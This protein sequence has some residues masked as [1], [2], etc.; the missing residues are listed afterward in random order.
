MLMFGLLRPVDPDLVPADLRDLVTD[1]PWEAFPGSIASLWGF[2]AAEVIEHVIAS[3][4]GYLIATAV[5]FIEQALA[6]IGAEHPERPTY[7]NNL[8]G[9]RHMLFQYRGERSDL[10]GALA[11]A[12]EAVALTAPEHAGRAARAALLASLYKARFDA[13]FD[14]TERREDL[15]AAVA[16]FAEAV[17]GLPDDHIDRA[18][19]LTGWGNARLTRYRLDRT[20]EDLEAAATILREAAKLNLPPISTVP[21]GLYDCASMLYQHFVAIGETADLDNAIDCFHTALALTGR[22]VTAEHLAEMALAHADAYLLTDDPWELSNFRAMAAEVARTLP[23]NDPLRMAITNCERRLAAITE[24][25]E[26]LRLRQDVLAR[27]DAFRRGD[28]TAVLSGAATVDATRLLRLSDQLSDD[29]SVDGPDLYAYAWLQWYRFFALPDTV[30]DDAFALAVDGFRLL[31]VHDVFDQPDS[32]PAVLAI[33]DDGPASGPLRQAVAL[34]FGGAPDGA[35]LD[36]AIRKLGRAIDATAPDSP[37]HAELLASLAGAYHERYLRDREPGDLDT[38]ITNWRGAVEGT[39]PTHPAY[40]AWLNALAAGHHARFRAC[41]DDADIDAAVDAARRADAATS[42]TDPDW[43]ATHAQVG[44]TSLARY[45]HRPDGDDLDEAITVLGQVVDATDDDHDHR[46]LYLSELADARWK[47]Y[48]RGRDRSDLE[49]AVEAYRAALHLAGVSVDT[50]D[51]TQ[52]LRRALVALSRLGDGQALRSAVH[53]AREALTVLDQDS[54]DWPMHAGELALTLVS[55]YELDGNAAALTEAIELL[56]RA[57]TRGGASAAGVAGALG[58]ALLKR[59]ERDGDRRDIDAAVNAQERALDATTGG[60]DQHATHLVNLGRALSSRYFHTGTV[61]DLQRAITSLRQA[62]DLLHDDA[63]R[64]AALNNLAE[65][66]RARYLMFRDAADLDEAVDACRTAARTTSDEVDRAIA[67]TDLAKV[68][69]ARFRHYGD[70]TDL[71]E[72]VDAARLALAVTPATHRRRPDRLIAL[73]ASLMERHARGEDRTDLDEAIAANRDA[74]KLAVS[75][76]QVYA[77]AASGLAR[78]LLLR[79]ATSDNPDDLGDAIDASRRTAAAIAADHPGRAEVL[80]VL[81]TAL[82]ARHQRTRAGADLAEAVEVLRSAA[83]LPAAGARSRIQA[84]RSWARVAETAGPPGAGLSGFEAAIRLLPLAVWHG[85]GP[86]ERQR[87]LRELTGLA[88]DAAAAAISAGRAEL[89]VELVDQGRS[90]LWAQV[91]ETTTDLTELAAVD[92][93]LAGRLAQVRAELEQPPDVLTTDRRITLAREWDALLD[94]ARA[95]DGF[96]DLLRPAG[97]GRLQAAAGDGPVVIVNV[98][99]YRCD[100][101]AVTAAGVTVIPLP[102]LRLAELTDRGNEYLTAL[103]YLAVGGAG[104]L[105]GRLQIEQVVGQTLRWLWDTIAGPVL[106]SLGY[107]ATDAPPRVWWCPTGPLTLLPLH[108]A[109]RDGD[110]NAVIDRVVSS[111]TST[112]RDLIRARRPAADGDPVDGLLVVALPDTP[113]QPALPFAADEATRLTAAYPGQHALLVGPDATVAAVSRELR[114]H[115]WVHFACHGGQDLAD[116][117]AGGVRLHDGVLT[118]LDLARERLDRAELAFLSACQTALGGV[119]LLDEA[120]NLAAALQ[121]AGFRHVVGTLWSVYDRTS[122]RLAEEVYAELLRTAPPDVGHLA[123][124]LHQAQRRLRASA[125]RSPLTWASYVHLGP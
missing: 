57:S 10:E 59:F 101:L 14:A 79:Y 120:V 15:D 32:I 77:T 88:S 47:R 56:E 71:D 21:R 100:A 35:M 61:D 106:D 12:R 111:Y 6:A 65:A 66:L 81:G 82:A 5:Y 41:G 20:Y 125:P 116:P 43:V 54:P 112:L 39:P 4:E 42:D 19:Y 91:L 63:R 70:G 76:P 53:V 23:D 108:A 49:G 69:V 13:R 107:R 105:A 28:S 104:T 118:V 84:A 51:M 16:G 102:A 122:A 72:A 55:S 90:V 113:D 67:H 95:I 44:M 1:V 87:Q 40:A 46:G 64:P 89:A 117:G 103:Q 3:R 62:T 9:A 48:E 2:Y 74:A 45:R 52:R 60:S 11:A 123:G 92:A 99:A 73:A 33:P 124:A 29:D 119:Y 24:P 98:S 114:R 50:L 94:R 68:L 36:K 30:D 31:S 97:F 83:E 110:G 7:L 58:I 80:T 75:E 96:A 85:V 26:R 86:A 17:P 109:G 78:A 121:L 25:D 27:V 37:Q 22:K 93:A 38:A 18:A 8:A 34:L 115:A